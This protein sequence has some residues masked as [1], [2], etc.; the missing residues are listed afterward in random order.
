MCEDLASDDEVSF[1]YKLV[2]NAARQLGRNIDL[3]CF[4][5]PVAAGKA[6]GNFLGL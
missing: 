6:L 5:T 1:T 3:R 4:D 2:K